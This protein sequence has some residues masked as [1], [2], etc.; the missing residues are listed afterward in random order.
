MIYRLFLIFAT[1][2]HTFAYIIKS[3]DGVSVTFRL[4]ECTSKEKD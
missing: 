2:T 1:H 4:N 3:H